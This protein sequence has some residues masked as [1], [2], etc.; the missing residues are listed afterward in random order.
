ME[1]EK[2]IKIGEK[3]GFETEVLFIKSY[4]VSVDL[5]GK[6]LDSFQITTSYGIGVRVIKDGKVGFAYANKFDENIVYKAMK[7]LVEDK[8]TKFA[9]PQKYKEPKGMFYKEI[10]DLDEEKLLEDLITM[11]DIALENNAIVLSGGISKEVGYAR[12]I[13]SNGVD[14][15]E[16]DTYFSASI[17]IM[18]DGET[19]YESKTQHNIFDVEEISYKALDL[20]KKSA[21]GKSLSYKGNIILSP[22]ALYELLPYTLMPAFSAENVQRDRSVLKG[23]IG[24]QIFGEN[25]TIIDDGTLDYALY[26]SKC[27]GEG[28]ATQRTVLVKDGVLKNYLYDIKRANKEGKISTGNASRGYNSLPYISPTNFIIEGTKNS[29]DDFDEYVYVNGVIGSH[30]SNPITGDFAVEIQNSY[31][32]KN[33]EIIPIKKGMFSGNI[34]EMFKEAIPLNDVEQR[35]KLISPSVVFNG[36]II[37]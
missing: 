24:E 7:N 36:E 1:L 22:R 8:Y 13:N 12:L 20:A 19:S 31:L 16:E 18:Y 15:E 6:S 32:Y 26:S 35:G 33:G 23:K 3:E 17:S 37:N 9:E 21:N 34:F 11:R 10:L 25:I 29:L 27:D 2:L 30:T 5:D 14:V 4:D 28:T